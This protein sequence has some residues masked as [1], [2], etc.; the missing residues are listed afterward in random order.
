MDLDAIFDGNSLATAPM[1]QPAE[2]PPIAPEPVQTA[3]EPE[4]APLEI[5][6][7]PTSQQD[8]MV[9]LMALL[10]TRDKLKAAERR[11]AEIDAAQVAR[12]PADVPDPYDDP[13]GFQDH[14]GQQ[15][16]NQALSQ[17]FDISET[18]ARDKHGDVTVTA[19]MEWG[20]QRAQANPGFRDEFLS[21]KNPIDW[22]VRQQKRD[23]LL[24]DVG[25]DPDAYVRRRA[26][27]LGLIAAPDA[28]AGMT[29]APG[30]QQAPKPAA[31]PRSIASAASSGN[32]HRDMA[33]GP[34]A[35]LDAVF[36]G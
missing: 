33:T 8:R 1:T 10:D 12:Q 35:A 28:G 14:V 26:A 25:E 24:A 32:G 21:Q 15:L 5:V 16:A 7:E 2:A 27:E 18:M 6:P 23:S 31:P 30:Q 3:P 9:P 22:V 11:L 4:A 17:R 29:P 34:M 19:A 36:K 13:Q 20:A